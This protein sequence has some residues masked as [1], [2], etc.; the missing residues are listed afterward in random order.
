RLV[1]AIRRRCSTRLCPA[2]LTPS[3]GLPWYSFH[4][5]TCCR[6]TT[7]HSDGIPQAIDLTALAAMDTM[8]N[9]GFTAT[10]PGMI[11]ASETYSPSC[12]CGSSIFHHGSKSGCRS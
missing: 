5:E 2:R 6:A 7:L 8:R 1:D 4:Q 12:T 10:A 11:E 3:I 9:V